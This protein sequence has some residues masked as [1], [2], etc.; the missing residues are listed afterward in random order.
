MAEHAAE[1]G[2]L[3]RVRAYGWR[4]ARAD[5]RAGAAVGAVLVPMAMTYA[6]IA[7]VPPVHGLYAS[8]VPLLVYPVLASSRHLA[9]GP[10]AID[11]MVLAGGLVGMAAVGS[12]EYVALAAL[13]SL[14]VGGLHLA[15]G[16]A[17]LDALVRLLSR[18]VVV[19]FMAAAP[20]VIAAS[21]L[22]PLVGL[23]VSRHPLVALLDLA[24]DAGHAHALTS[25]VGMAAVALLVGLRRWPRV[26]GPLVVVVIGAASSWA[27][28]LEALGVAVVGPVP[29]G[30]PRLA[31]P[32]PGP[33]LWAAARAVAPT[34]LALALVQL[35]GVTTFSR[36][37]S[38]RFDTPGRPMRDV[39]AVGAA[40]LAG[41]LFGA[42]PVSASLSRSA[43]N[44]EAGAASAASN[45]VAAGVVG[46]A[47]VALTPAFAPIPR[48][49][50][51]AV[52][53]VSALG[54]V[55]RRAIPDLVRVHRRDGAV[56]VATAVVTLVV[57]IQEGL[58]VGVAVSVLALLQAAG[59]AEV[60]V[61]GREPGTQAYRDVAR[62]PDAQE[63]DGVVLL[64]PRSALSFANA[65]AFADQVQREAAGAR[66]VVLDVR[67]VADL[68]AT[69]AVA[70]ER[71]SSSLEDEGVRV[72]LVSPSPTGALEQG[73]PGDARWLPSV[74]EAVDRARSSGPS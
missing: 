48:A 20:L 9:V 43:V 16:V 46:L 42:V 50:L 5:L 27:F 18:P 29:P 32:V 60:A 68:D 25:G 33:D 49:V 56:A 14:C 61:L 23:E 41:G 4:G 70:L 62:T 8:L 11:M 1:A 28:G 6:M 53:V 15:V 7:G 63:V 52:I 73:G 26:P 72:Y 66:A 17:R 31:L 38:D 3:R 59:Q 57:G 39:L 71:L 34:A 55:E 2:P 47:L 30:L 65:H 67:D 74:R 13:T 19:G 12:P 58:L 45:A 69:A 10:A 21:Q 22:G 64:R 36:A 35:V 40:N 24:R 44:V 37:F 54:L 51:A